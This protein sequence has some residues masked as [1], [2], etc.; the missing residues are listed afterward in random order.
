MAENQYRLGGAAACSILITLSLLQL[1]DWADRSILAISL[2]HIKQ[3][4]HLTDTQAGMLPSLLQLGI[5]TFALPSAIVAD[6]WARRK[7]IPIMDIIWSVF[8]VATG[9]AT[10]FWHLLLARLMVGVGEAGYG[11]AGQT[12]LGVIFPKNIRSRVMGIFTM[13]H[14]LGAAMGLMVGG[15]LTSSTQNWRLPF[16]LFGALGLVMAIIVFLEFLA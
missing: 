5:A 2:Q 7:L 11:P 3:E 15:I 6:R 12:W 14:P 9:L 8:S 4:F 13:C 1:I 10:Q 16:Y